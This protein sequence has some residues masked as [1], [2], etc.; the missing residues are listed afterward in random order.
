MNQRTDQ[1][2]YIIFEGID[3]AGKSSRIQTLTQALEMRDFR[4]KCLFE[5]TNGPFGKEI[6]SRARHGPE[7]TVEEELELFIKDRRAHIQGDLSQSLADYDVVIQDRS[8]L[9]SAAY[10]S[11]K[12]NC[13]HSPQQ[14]LELHDF[15]PK[16][17]LVVYLDLDVDTALTRVGQ[18]GESDAFENAER[19]KRVRAN[20]LSI[21]QS[22]WLCLDATLSPESLDHAI[23]EAVLKALQT[24]PKAQ[25]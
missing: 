10:Q 14:I 7:M 3:G 5:P 16:P 4:V 9:S 1:A 25:D 12:I 8:Y 24:K 6:R 23:I 13:P 22:N 11:A 18:R 17:D 20:Y 19:L 2:L 21:Q 15:V